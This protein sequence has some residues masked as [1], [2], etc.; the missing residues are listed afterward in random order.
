MSPTAK[1]VL[2]RLGLVPVTLIAIFTVNF[3]VVMLMPGGPVDQLLSRQ[4]IGSDAGSLAERTI[5]FGSQGDAGVTSP[6]ETN[7]D[8]STEVNTSLEARRIE[9]LR[10]QFGLN[11]PLWRSYFDTLWAYVRFD[12]GN[13]LTY[14]RPVMTLIAERIPV[15]FGLGVVTFVVGTFITFFFGITK[16]YRQN[17]RYDAWTTTGFIA[18]DAVPNLVLAIGLLTLFAAGGYYFQP[19]GLIPRGGIVSDNWGDLSLWGKIKDYLWHLAAP[20]IVLLVGSYAAGTNFLRNAY[21]DQLNQTYVMTARAKGLSENQIFWRHVFRNGGILIIPGIPATLIGL[22]FTGSIIVERIF[23]IEGLALLGLDALSDRDFKT[24]LATT[25]V[26]SLLGL[27]LSIVGDLMLV[28]VD[29][30]ISFGR[31]G[32]RN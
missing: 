12:F 10:E 16:A 11:K 32:A 2:V 7:T 19:E 1:Y 14:G 17:T 18:I 21:A 22:L 4:M 6:E 27:I 24:F 23:N 25:W 28:A 29:R 9:D 3:I 5:Q 13:S 15:L 31:V 20:A 30:R 8:R 26:F